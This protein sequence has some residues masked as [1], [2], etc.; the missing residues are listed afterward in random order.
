MNPVRWNDFSWERM[1]AAVDA[2]RERACRGYRPV[3]LPLVALPLLLT[4]GCGRD[5]VQF[6][7]NLVYFRVQ[8]FIEDAEDVQTKEVQARIHDTQRVLGLFFGTPDHPRLPTIEGIEFDAILDPEML[9]MAAGSGT[10]ARPGYETG[11][12]RKMCARCHGIS[13]SGTGP[14]AAQL[15]PYPR[16]FRPKLW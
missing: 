1:V 13:G 6:E 11:L 7:P 9:Q 3:F 10:D 12:Y 4:I 14:E 15:D 8:D 2:V 5:T 16:D